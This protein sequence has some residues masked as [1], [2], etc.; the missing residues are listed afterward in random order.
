MMAGPCRFCGTALHRSFVDLGRSPLSNAFL[1]AEQIRSMEPH[2]PLHV[3]VCESCLLVQLET[4]QQPETIFSDYLYF[5]SF[6]EIWLRH[7]EAYADRMTRAL[8]LGAGSLV[9]EIA[10]NDGYLLQYFQQLNVGVLG[11]EPAA[12]VARVAQAKGIPTEIAFF[13]SATARRLADTGNAADLICANNVLAHAPDLNDFVAGFRILLNPAGT[14]TVEFPHLLALIAECQFD[15]IYREHFSYFSLLVV[16]KVLARHG[17]RVFDVDRLP[18][19]G[20]SLRI[21]ACHAEDASRVPTER[22]HAVLASERA[23]GAGRA[24]DLR[25]L[26]RHRHRCEVPGAGIPPGRAARRQ[27]GCRRRR[28]GQ[29]Q[30]AAQ[31]LRRRPG[32]DPLHC[33]PQPTQ[34]GALPARCSD[35]DLRARTPAGGEAGLCL[36]PALEH[37]GRDYRPNARS[38]RLG[39]SFRRADPTP[40]DPLIL[41]TELELPGAFIVAPERRVDPRGWFARTYCRDEFAA[42]GLAYDFVQCST[43]CS[44]R[45]GTLRGMHFQI[46]PHE[47]AKLVRLRAVRSSTSCST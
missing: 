21:H 39:W 4:F 14:V 45:R 7:A 38:A 42:H 40:S 11:V 28:A 15:T 6:S 27:A 24:C 43:S 12:N 17:L 19:H 34:A 2:Y 37:Q 36:H 31:L 35:P 3:Y 47:E 16:D 9:V 46:S 33:R 32:A 13:G 41:F 44:A 1:T 20:G 25:P 26:R 18:T 30:H 23:A 22:F 29:G 10:S 8:R 5:S